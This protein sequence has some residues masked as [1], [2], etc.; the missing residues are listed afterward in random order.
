[1]IAATDAYRNL[2]E[3]LNKMPVGFPATKSGVEINLLKAIFTSEQAKVTTHLG[4]KHKTVDQ[5]FET[6]KQEVGSKE[7]LKC[8]LDEIVSKG[9]ITR[10][11][12]NGKEQYAVLPLLL[13]GMYEHQ[14]K[15][16]SPDFLSNLGQYMQNEFGYELATSKLPKMRVIPIE[17]SVEAEHRIA[18]Y[19]ELH[20]LIEHA[21]EHI[22]IQ[23]CMCRKVYDLQGK[24][25]QTTERREVC[26]SFGDLADLYSE[27]GWGRRIS[28]QEALEIARKNEEEGLVLMPGNE[29]EASFMCACCGDCCGMLSVAK[30]FPR[31][32]D[33]VAS[34]YYAQVNTELCKGRGTC[35]K[36]CPLDAVKVADKLSSVDLARCIGCGLCVPTCPE[37]AIGL[38]KKDR[39]TVPPKTEENLYDTLMAG[40][41]AQQQNL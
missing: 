32:A 41:K 36:R 39:E 37:N 25:C 15:R 24:H 17:E 14:L 11:E 3:H 4:Y 21:G 16:I 10:R 13:W 23:E 33:V 5:I 7:E 38:V 9:G 27:E 26:M 30:N 34:N 19:D 40:K 2:Q 1:M 29:Q 18:T 12:R 28:Q 22:A 31:P 35:V 8:I 6:A 20:H